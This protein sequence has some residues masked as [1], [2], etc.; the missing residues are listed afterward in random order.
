MSDAEAFYTGG[1]I[2]MAAMYLDENIYCAINSEAIDDYYEED[3]IWFYDH[4]SEDDDIE[5]P[6]QNPI[7]VKLYKELAPDE[8]DL[9][10]ELRDELVKEAWW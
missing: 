6:C 4:R 9:Y 5:Y 1:N 3:D 2:W 7:K 10:W 8:L